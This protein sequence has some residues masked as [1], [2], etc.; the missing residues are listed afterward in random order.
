MKSRCTNPSNRQWADYG[1][2]GITVCQRWA[3]SFEAF[4][5]DMGPRP[6]AKHQIDR[7]NNDRGYEPG[8]CRWVLSKTNN[9]NKRSNRIIEFQGQARTL[10]EW[11]RQ[12]GIGEP[13]L[14][15]RLSDLGWSVERALTTPSTAKR[16]GPRKGRLIEFDGRALTATQWVAETGIPLRT[17]LSRLDKHGWSVERALTTPVRKGR[18]AA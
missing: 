16:P 2:R 3:D 4:L 12:I 10:T 15:I 18:R 14:W 1:G 9:S 8:N 5:E 6:S 7:T 13:T 11:A 17:L